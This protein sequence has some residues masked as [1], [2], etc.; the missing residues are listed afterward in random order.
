MWRLA[1]LAG[2]A[3]PRVPFNMARG[4][5]SDARKGHKNQKLKKTLPGDRIVLDRGT[6]KLA[7]D[8]LH[9]KRVMT[10]RKKW[11]KNWD[12]VIYCSDSCRKQA[13]QNRR[14]V[15]KAL[16]QELH[17][18]TQEPPAEP[19]T[20]WAWQMQKQPEPQLEP[21]PQ[22]EPHSEPHSEPEPEPEPE[23]ELEPEQQGPAT[24]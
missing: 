18:L 20:Q 6:N 15:S 19:V 10:W 14:R 24:A 21:E 22:S 11:E 1:S 4:A 12:T 7:R 2:T 16:T 23:P 8:C 3:R 17:T 5:A 13:A 9:C